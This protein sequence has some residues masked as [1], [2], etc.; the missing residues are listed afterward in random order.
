MIRW[1]LALMRRPDT[2]TPLGAQLVEL[3]GQHLRVDHDAV[4]DHAQLARVEDPGRDQVELPRLALA[5]DRV[6]G[7]VAALEADHQVGL[8][9]E[10]V[11]DLALALVAPLGADDHDAGHA[12][13][14]LGAVGR[15]A[16]VA[17]PSQ[18]ASSRR[19]RRP[20]RDRGRAGRAEHRQRLAA[21]LVQARHGALADLLRRAAAWSRFVVSTI[22][23]P[24]S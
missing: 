1:A 5:D 24:S 2:S 9:G 15:S 10:Q 22:A 16:T 18:K 6:A 11:G 17:A 13:V 3:V 12:A 8:L 7:V 4:A 21:H 19:R 23:L 14:S 20:A